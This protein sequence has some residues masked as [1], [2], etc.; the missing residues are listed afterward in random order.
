MTDNSLR[1][2]LGMLI[3]EVTFNLESTE[4]KGLRTYYKGVLRGL[5]M[6]LEA[7]EICCEVPKQIPAEDEM[8]LIALA[9]MRKQEVVKGK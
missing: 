7:L 6:S 8:H 1:M 2:H 3:N 9:A 4:K 5:A